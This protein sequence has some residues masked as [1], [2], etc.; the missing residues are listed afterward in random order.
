MA[1]KS[2]LLLVPLHYFDCKIKEIK[3][4]EF[5]KIIKL[6]NVLKNLVEQSVIFDRNR[7][8]NLPKYHINHALIIDNIQKK[9][10]ILDVEICMKLFKKGRIC[11]NEHFLIN[12]KN[13]NIELVGFDPIFPI[14]FPN[15]HYQLKINEHDSFIDYT[16]KKLAILLKVHQKF[17]NFDTA[18]MEFVYS[19]ETRDYMEEIAKYCICLEAI[20]LKGG[21]KEELSYKFATR[22][23]VLISNKYSVR[24]EIFEFAKEL[25]KL[26]S[27]YVHGKGK[28]IRSR[29]RIYSKEFLLGDFLNLCETQVRKAIDKY[30]FLV[31]KF[32]N[33]EDI[34]IY[35]DS[36]MLGKKPIK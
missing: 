10:S 18:L 2:E 7:L 20:L 16:Q 25:Y 19:Q 28:K 29:I 33:S 22:L 21:E 35:L 23:A 26:R 9:V 15:E 14:F 1:E 6:N 17:P 36:L 32:E 3:I 11:F 8:P 12:E 30:F 4:N 27:Q 24:K 31:T 34:I 13:Q 5:I